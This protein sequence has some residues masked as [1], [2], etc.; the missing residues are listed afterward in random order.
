MAI[1]PTFEALGPERRLQT[2]LVE[3]RAGGDLIEVDAFDRDDEVSGFVVSRHLTL[4]SLATIRSI[5]VEKF[6]ANGP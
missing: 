3:L 2:K 5:A 4:R 6:G 1:G